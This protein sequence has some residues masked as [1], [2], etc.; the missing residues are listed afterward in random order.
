MDRMVS[1][2]TVVENVFCEKFTYYGEVLGLAQYEGKRGTVM[3]GRSFHKRH[4]G[5]N[6]GFMPKGLQGR[7]MTAAK[8]YSKKHGLVGIVDEAIELHDEVVLI[9]RKFSNRAEIHD[10]IRVQLGLLAVLIE[11][12]VGKPVRLAY[13]V[14]NKDHRSEIEVNVDEGV[15]AFAIDMLGRT[16]KT[17]NTGI[18][19][20]SRYDN[21]CLNCCYRRICPV[22]SLNTD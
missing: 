18:M 15:K 5:T 1:V 17:I 11:E 7:K 16:K 10:T 22:G 8:F 3:S 4:E 13:V 20:E 9:E 21:R 14:F 19:P 12:N 6:Q 2:T